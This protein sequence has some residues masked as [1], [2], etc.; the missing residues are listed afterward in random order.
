MHIHAGLLGRCGVAKPPLAF[1]SVK[2]KIKVFNYIGAMLKLGN[3]NIGAG[4]RR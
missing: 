3:I 4:P 1:F 2:N